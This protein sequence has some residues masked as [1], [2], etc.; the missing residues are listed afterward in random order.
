[1]KLTLQTIAYN[2]NEGKCVTFEQCVL[3]A[4]LQ[5]EEYFRHNILQL[6]F[7]FPLDSKD[8]SGGK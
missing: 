3:W 7:N 6:L 2:L 4:R 5:F 8:K 1:M